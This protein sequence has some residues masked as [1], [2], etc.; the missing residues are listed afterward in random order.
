[1]KCRGVEKDLRSDTK[2][3]RSQED[4]EEGFG[5]RWSDNTCRDH[6]PGCSWGPLWETDRWGQPRGSPCSRPQDGDPTSP[7]K[8]RSS[9]PPQGPRQS[10]TRP[11]WNTRSPPFSYILSLATC[12]CFL[13]LCDL[14]F[15]LLMIV[16]LFISTCL[17]RHPS[18]LVHVTTLLCTNLFLP[19][20]TFHPSKSNV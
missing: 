19:V 8:V 17:S 10:P 4:E 5:V 16:S 14:I 18:L 20:F 12:F 2:L 7:P 15:V 9:P 11:R 1:M 3:Y 13:N 6:S